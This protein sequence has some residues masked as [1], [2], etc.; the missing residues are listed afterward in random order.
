MQVLNFVAMGAFYLELKIIL[1]IFASE[2]LVG[3]PKAQIGN[4][5]LM[6]GEPCGFLLRKKTFLN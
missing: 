5:L 2:L 6:L 4:H 3:N 1:Y